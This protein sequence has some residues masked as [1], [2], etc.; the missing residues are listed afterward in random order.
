MLT[1]AETSMLILLLETGLNLKIN[2]CHVESFEFLLV[3]LFQV[4]NVSFS[5]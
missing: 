4:T 2:I 3:Q 1:K 5:F